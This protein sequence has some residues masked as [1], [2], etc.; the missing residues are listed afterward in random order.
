MGAEN[1]GNKGIP[2]EIPG[3]RIRYFKLGWKAQKE[4]AIK[5]GSVDKAYYKMMGLVGD[6]GKRL[7]VEDIKE[8][9]LCMMEAFVDLLFEGLVRDAEKNE[10]TLTRD[11]ICDILD[12]VGI[13]AMRAII[14]KGLALSLPDATGAD[15]TKG[16]TK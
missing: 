12:D 11:K 1:I 15:P 16:Q 6:D 13:V 14:D 9:T 3:E 8:M 4:L 10:E 7:P 2:L 5:H